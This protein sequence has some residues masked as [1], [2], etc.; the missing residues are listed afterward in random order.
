MGASLR[1]DWLD[2]ALRSHSGWRYHGSGGEAGDDAIRA[3]LLVV[4]R[5]SDLG[6]ALAHGFSLEV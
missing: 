4:D 3:Q 6:A 5:A 2:E 1:Q